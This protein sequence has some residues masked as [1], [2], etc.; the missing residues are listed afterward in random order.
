M[1]GAIS[2]FSGHVNR[3]GLIPAARHAVRTY[4]HPRRDSLINTVMPARVE[5]PCCGWA[6][7]RF[8]DYYF[9]MGDAFPEHE[10][11]Q[12]ESHPRHRLLYLWIK[13]FQPLS[14]KTGRGLILAP[15]ES[16]APCWRDLPDLV[17]I[18]ADVVRRPGAEVLADIQHL[19]FPAGSMSL[20]WCHHVLAYLRDDRIGLAEL[21][22][23]LDPQTGELILSENWGAGKDTI[24]FGRSREDFSNEWRHYGDDFGDRIRAAGLEP[25]RI[26]FGF[27]ALEHRRFGLSRDPIYRC[28]PARSVIAA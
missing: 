4:W 19:P 21:L 16:L 18:G 17:T 24:E 6:G 1:L 12:C 25:E 7:R 20:V 13:R 10:C 2:R 8:Q 22:R 9:F 14:G 27:T 23:V 3:Y 5:C 26:E 11:P 15:E 28:Q